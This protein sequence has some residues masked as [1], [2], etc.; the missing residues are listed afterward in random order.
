MLARR[1]GLGAAQVGL[2]VLVACGSK[3][4]VS[5][6]PTSKVT[7]IDLGRSINADRTIKDAA[8]SFQPGDTIYAS[9]QTE[10]L[11]SVKVTARWTF[12]DGQTVDSTVQMVPASGG[13]IRTEFHVW[14]PGGW[15]LGKYHLQVALD[16]TVSG[17][18][19]FE[20]RQ[21]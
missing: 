10:T 13:V 16:S 11:G 6:V 4:N 2:L 18:K 7:A 9:V 17:V 15:P 5:G 20:V 19:E 3:A 14:K 1:V 12:Q 8:D 21:P